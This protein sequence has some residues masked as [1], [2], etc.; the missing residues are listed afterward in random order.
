MTF[1]ELVSLAA[2]WNKNGQAGEDASKDV[3][4]LDHLDK[5]AAAKVTAH[6]GVD[7]L[8][9]VKD[10]KGQWKIVQVLWQTVERPR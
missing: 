7:Y 4:V 3:I 8:H 6:W 5:T 1:D 10:E 2:E 9:L